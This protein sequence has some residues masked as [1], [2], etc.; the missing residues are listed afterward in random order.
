MAP[1]VVFCCCSLSVSSRAWP[2]LDTDANVWWFKNLIFRYV[3]LKFSIFQTHRQ[4][5]LTFIIYSYFFFHSCPA[6]ISWSFVMFWTCCQQ[7]RL[8]SALWWLTWLGLFSCVLFTFLLLAVINANSGNK[9]L[10]A[11]DIPTKSVR[12]EFLTDKSGTWQGLLLLSL[13][14]FKAYFVCNDWLFW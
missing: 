9:R 8:Q 3:F 11:A 1:G 14:C 10:T 2:L 13:I 5:F 4:L 6:L 7:G 12:L